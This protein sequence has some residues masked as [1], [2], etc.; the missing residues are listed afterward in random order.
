MSWLK[1]LLGRARGAGWEPAPVRGPTSTPTYRFTDSATRI[2]AIGDLHGRI[3]LV[4]QLAPHLD[5]L[6]RD[7]EKRLIEVY[8][9]DYVDRGP[10]SMAVVEFL[11]RRSR[12]TDRTVVCLLGNHEQ[13]LL[14]GL[15]N[16]RNF[17]KWLEFGG[18][19]TI[20][21]YGLS[22]EV[23][24]S[25]I[26]RIRQAFAASFPVEHVEFLKSLRLYYSHSEFLFVH[27]GLR[28]GVALADQTPNDLLWIRD[29]FLRSAA[30]F[31]ATVVH[32][33][34]PTLNPE[35]RRNRIGID[36]GAYYSSVLSCLLITSEG[37][38][39]RQTGRRPKAP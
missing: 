17:E 35:F 33:H 2:A 15:E 3:D 27:A 39:V 34:S 31:G 18:R 22:M 26:S 12:F 21:S 29:S 30:N 20:A 6:A 1:R 37:I 10:N 8:L 7:T 38:S 32:G 16:D 9:G 11:I 28:P 23:S 19:P 36:T 13:A 14:S 4:H 25:A 5:L 24:P